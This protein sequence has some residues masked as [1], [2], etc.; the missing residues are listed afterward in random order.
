MNAP[1]PQRPKVVV[2]HWVHNEVIELLARHCDLVANNSRDSWSRDELIR[3]CRDADGLIAFMPDAVDG[4]FLVACPRLRVIA[5]AL[6]GYDN[7]DAAACTR[8]GVWLTIVPGMLTG[9]TAELAVGLVIGLTRR[10]SAG[11]RW[12]RS[13]QFAGWR[14]IHYG[15]GL[16]GSIVGILGMG[17]VG[18]AIARRLAGFEVRLAYHDLRLLPGG[19]ELE[20]GV[21]RMSREGLLMAADILIS[22]LP[23]TPQTRHLIDAD[24]LALMK[25]GSYLVNV[26]RGSVVD[27]AAV[28]AALKGDRL[29]GYAADVF[30]FEDWTQRERPAAIPPELLAQRDR[31]L[32]TSH[33]GSA[34]DA[35]RRDIALYAARA[36][37]QAL[38]GERPQGAVNAPEG[39]DHEFELAA[40]A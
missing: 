34:V 5:C 12:V 31:T 38:R 36:V 3:R 33:M 9:P 13:G 22:T 18:R 35:V 30:E 16:A 25:P 20:L 37:V 19:D 39:R 28:A 10:I 4:A 40:N 11:D 26:G 27:E 8:R 17:A 23:L 15:T 32:F 6:K 21:R 14:P 1:C 24:A 2:S 7:F 29:A